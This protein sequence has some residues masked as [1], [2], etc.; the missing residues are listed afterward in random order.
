[1]TVLQEIILNLENDSS[2]YFDHVKLETYKNIISNIKKYLPKED[3][4]LRDAWKTAIQKPSVNI[5]SYLN[6]LNK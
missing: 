5:E 4:Q 6:N 1:M 3:Q 2:Q